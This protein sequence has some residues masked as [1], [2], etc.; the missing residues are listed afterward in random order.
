MIKSFLLQGPD[1]FAHETV[2]NL[3]CMVDTR[4]RIWTFSN[5]RS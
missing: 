4:M 5:K 3:L 1:K 2:D